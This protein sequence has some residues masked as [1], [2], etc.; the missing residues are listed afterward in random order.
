MRMTSSKKPSAEERSEATIVAMIDPSPS[1]DEL[2]RLA[3]L[4]SQ[5][6]SSLQKYLA[7]PGGQADANFIALTSAALGLNN[8]SD[9]IAVMQLHLATDAGL[10]AVGVINQATAELQKALILRD[11]I[12]T[13][14]AIV[15]AVVGFGASIAAGDAGSIVSSGQSLL[16]QLAQA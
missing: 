15:Q 14:L 4:F 2:K 7:S 1:A 6:E 16:K 5:V 11:K 10:Q 12:T 13:D 8:A 3:A 9:S